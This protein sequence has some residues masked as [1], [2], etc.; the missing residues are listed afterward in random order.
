MVFVA[1][2][3]IDQAGGFDAELTGTEFQKLQGKV[4][5]SKIDEKPI[6]KRG[7]TSFV[8]Q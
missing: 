8:E 4:L 5:K 2:N 1:Q 6:V 7:S 3:H